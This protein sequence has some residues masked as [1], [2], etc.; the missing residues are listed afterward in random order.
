[1][2]VDTLTCTAPWNA[3]GDQ[4]VDLAKAL[5][6]DERAHGS[7]VMKFSRAVFRGQQTRHVGWGQHDERVL[8]ELRGSYAHDWYD[9]ALQ[10]AHRVSRLDLEVSV[11][12]EPYDR[13]L[14]YRLYFT[15]DDEARE[16]GRPASWRLEGTAGGG[17]T[18][19]IGKGASR[20][21]ARLYEAEYKHR[22]EGLENCWRYEVQARRERAVQMA[23]LI[24]VSD[25][26]GAWAAACVHQHFAKRGVTPIF[27]S[28]DLAQ[29]AALPKAETD[30]E[31]SLRWLAT[32]AAPALRRHRAWGSYEAAKAA[33]GIHTDL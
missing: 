24:R 13:E 16:R 27:S 7:K 2:G 8:L 20:F 29:V 32:S 28:G 23:S 10:L 17:T 14:A 12:Q 1:M 26:P 15:K 25:D 31:R 22:G 6:E 21:Q 3:D 33:L 30:R 11:C 5:M 9:V 4:L 19:Y 18:L